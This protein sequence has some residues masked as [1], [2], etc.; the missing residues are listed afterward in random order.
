MNAV[1]HTSARGSVFLEYHR[2]YL[3]TDPEA[4]HEQDVQAQ[5]FDDVNLIEVVGHTVCVKTGIH[6]GW[7]GVHLDI[8]DAEPDKFGDWEDTAETEIPIESG[9]YVMS[10]ANYVPDELSTFTLSQDVYMVRV[11]AVGRDIAPDGVGENRDDPFEKYLV[12]VWPAT[13]R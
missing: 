1:Q 3:T 6:T 2:W 13:G 10:L 11:S 12:Q 9:L 7:V 5:S 4:F 8:L